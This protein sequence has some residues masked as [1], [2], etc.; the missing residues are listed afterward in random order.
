MNLIHKKVIYPKIQ[1][2]F[3]FNG[4]FIYAEIIGAELREAVESM[5]A[6]I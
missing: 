2:Y 1:F 6:I 5:K 4:I 3:I